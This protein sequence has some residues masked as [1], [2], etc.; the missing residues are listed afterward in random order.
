M[1][2]MTAQERREFDGYLRQCTDAQVVGVRDKEDARGAAGLP[3]KQMAV[4][5]AT[6]RNIELP[7]IKPY[8][9]GSF[10]R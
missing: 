2:K 5:E 6:R 9:F 4:A 3:Y 8:R 10:G 7:P 1:A